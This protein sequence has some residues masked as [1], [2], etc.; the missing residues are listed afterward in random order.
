[1][2]YHVLLVE[3]E[4]VIRESIKKSIHWDRMPIQLAAEAENGTVDL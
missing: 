1:M 3:D 2:I 4:P